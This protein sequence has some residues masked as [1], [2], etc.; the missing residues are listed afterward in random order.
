MKYKV[1]ALHCTALLTLSSFCIIS[2]R[3]RF[4][5]ILVHNNKLESILDF[6]RIVLMH[7]YMNTEFSGMKR[8]QST[9]DL[10]NTFPLPRP[11]KSPQQSLTTRHSEVDSGY[12]TETSGTS[13]SEWSSWP[14]YW[15][16]SH[17]IIIIIGAGVHEGG[18]PTVLT[19][20]IVLSIP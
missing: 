19:P 12:Y 18:H 20:Y 14:T 6:Y 8:S 17:G 11:L 13:H 5:Y 4:T 9:S 2:C 10:H 1:H 3:H 16:A 7:H 15:K